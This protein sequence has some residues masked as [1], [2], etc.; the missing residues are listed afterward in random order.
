MLDKIKAGFLLLAVPILI[1]VLNPAF[2]DVTAELKMCGNCHGEDG[3]GND[4]DVP[5]IAGIPEII[6]EDALF[7]YLDGD[8]HCGSMPLMCNIVSRL[9]E[10]KITELAAHYAALPYEPANEDFDAD[11]AAR[12]KA[13]HESECLICHGSGPEASEASIL[14]GQRMAYLR[15]ALQQYAAG[16]RTQ[17][18]AMQEK[19]SQL[20]E[21]DIE[22][23]LNY[24]ASYRK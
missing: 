21:S 7:A 11:L 8:R 22:A 18:P 2:G 4:P 6:Q 20:S 15:Y 17:L 14:H 12:G 5:I 13:L 9:S 19:T 10:D 23:L 1:G 3:I 16:E 24:Y